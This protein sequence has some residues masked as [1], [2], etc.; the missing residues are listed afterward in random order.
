[1]MSIGMIVSTKDLATFSEG[2]IVGTEEGKHDLLRGEDSICDS[3]VSNGKE[4]L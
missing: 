4:T 2:E 1:M 3:E